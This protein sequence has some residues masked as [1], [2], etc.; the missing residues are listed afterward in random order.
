M[1]LRYTGTVAPHVVPVV[2]AGRQMLA[3]QLGAL[4]KLDLP[5]RGPS[6]GVLGWV[7][8]WTLSWRPVLPA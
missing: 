8:H 2:G 6:A 7:S 5:F 4:Q 3:S 1:L